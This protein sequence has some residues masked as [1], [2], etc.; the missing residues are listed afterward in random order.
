VDD[1]AD[2]D[3]ETVTGSFRLSRRQVFQAAGLA[4]LLEFVPACSGSPSKAVGTTVPNSAGSG[5]VVF[6]D[7]QFLVVEA[8]TARLIPGPNDD[9]SEIGHPGAREAGVARYIDRMLGALSTRPATIY[10]GGPFSDRNGASGD[11]MANFIP[12]TPA[13]FR[14]WTRRL[15]K[16]RSQY[17]AGVEALDHAAGGDF[18]VAT[19]AVQDGVL[20]RNP[21]G[22]TNLMFGHAIEGMYSVP[23]YGG[24]S[25]LVGWRDIG[26]PGDAQPVG[27][28]AAQVSTSDGPDAYEPSTLAH[29]VLSLVQAG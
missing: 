19:P 28:S 2:L 5:H 8:A 4:G 25:G 20:V 29:Q 17:A 13:Q 27:Y 21:G 6:S 3:S 9:P 10:A 12:L 18:A 16:L 14:G 26:F 7:H 23:E 22:F 15:A 24:N 1:R 11:D